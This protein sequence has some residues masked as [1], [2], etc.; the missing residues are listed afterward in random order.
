M[1][2]IATLLAQKDRRKLLVPFFTVGYPNYKTSL[3]L[4]R[5]GLDAGA[6]FV[7]LGMPFSDPMADGPDIQFASQTALD[8]GTNMHQVF[9]AVATL[10]KANDQPVLLMGYYNPVYAYGDD[11]FARTASQVGVDGL[12]IPDLPADEAGSLRTAASKSGLSMVFLVSPTSSPERIKL[13]DKSC[14]DFVY[15]V[16][17]TGVTGGRSRFDSS[18]T[19][20]LKQLSQTLS[21]P[22]VAGFG[23]STPK[24]A[25]QLARYTDGVV[26]GSALIQTY[27]SARNRKSGLRDVARLLGRIRKALK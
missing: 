1:N 18:T 24:T 26:I 2:R 10:R 20:Y 23:V 8:H 14:T 12:I 17:V 19:A 9:D 15:A 7:E 21:K 4:V 16:A 6:D 27:R 25:V 5:V 11:A 3:E 22:F 13:I